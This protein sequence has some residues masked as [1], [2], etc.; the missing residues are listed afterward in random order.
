MD[1]HNGR[2]DRGRAQRQDPRG[3]RQRA[4]KDRRGVPREQDSSHSGLDTAGQLV[5]GHAHGADLRPLV[6]R[7][8]DLLEAAGHT[9][10]NT[11]A[12]S[13][14]HIARRLLR[15]TRQDAARRE[16]RV[17]LRGVGGDRPRN[18]QRPPRTSVRRPERRDPALRLHIGQAAVARQAAGAQRPLDT[19]N[20]GHTRPEPAAYAVDTRC[21]QIQDIHIVLHIGGHGQLLAHIDHRQPPAAPSDTRQLDARLQGAA[22]LAALA[23]RAAGRGAPHIPLSGECRRD[24]QLVALL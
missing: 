9:A 5:A 15:R 20:G 18:A 7:Q 13:C 4:D 8:D 1:R 3:R 14:A 10:Q 16:W 6:E 22:H 21:R 11:R 12:R 24:V 23:Q 19:H 2:A 17:R